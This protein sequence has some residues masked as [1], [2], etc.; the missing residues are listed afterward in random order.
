MK[1]AGCYRNCAAKNVRKV[2]KLWNIWVTLGDNLKTLIYKSFGNRAFYD[3]E[4][5]EKVV[6]K[7]RIWKIELET[8]WK[9]SA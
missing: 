4:K 1:I 5:D 2:E 8:K 3:Y 6:K 9:T 7:I